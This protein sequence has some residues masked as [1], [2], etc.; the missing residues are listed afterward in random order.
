[1]AEQKT[2][3]PLIDPSILEKHTAAAAAPAHATP[4]PAP[5][6][7]FFWGTGRRKTACARVRIKP[8][9]GKLIVNKKEL[10]K[11]FTQEQDRQAR[12]PLIGRIYTRYQT[13]LFKS[14]SMD[15]DDL[16]YNTN[17]L[18]RDHDDILYKY[19][20][21]FRFIMVDEYQDTMMNLNLSW[22]L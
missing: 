22:Y 17:V 13:R 19:Q 6:G 7:G 20:D 12:K 8:G 3:S 10:H 2:D 11:F 16:L 18:L 9:E 15:F 4:K 1:M 21:K 14:G 5:K